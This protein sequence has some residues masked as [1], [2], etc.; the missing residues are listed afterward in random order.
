MGRIGTVII[1]VL[2]LASVPIAA[3]AM[4]YASQHNVQHQTYVIESGRLSPSTPR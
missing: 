3:A 2:I 1:L 4:L